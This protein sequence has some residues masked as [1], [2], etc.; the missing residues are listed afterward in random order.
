MVGQDFAPS[1]VRQERAPGSGSDPKIQPSYSLR[2]AGLLERS[3]VGVQYLLQEV[4]SRD[5][6]YMNSCSQFSSGEHH[7]LSHSEE[8][9][10]TGC[11]LDDDSG[12]GYHAT[13][14]L[15]NVNDAAVNKTRQGQ[16][17]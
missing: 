10:P 11:V 13:R 7:C 3:L 17:M 15:A 16:C 4:T 6:Q 1:L 8:S 14:F 12:R 5:A 2:H 9:F